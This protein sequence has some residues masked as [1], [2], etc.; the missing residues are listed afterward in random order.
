MRPRLESCLW[1]SPSVKT[2]GLCQRRRWRRRLSRTCPSAATEKTPAVCDVGAAARPGTICKTG[3]WFST[4]SHIWKKLELL[5]LKRKTIFCCCF[6][7][8]DISRVSEV[9]PALP[10]LSVDSQRLRS[11][12]LV[13]TWWHHRGGVAFVEPSNQTTRT[14]VRRKTFR[15]RFPVLPEGEGRRSKVSREDLWSLQ[16]SVSLGGRMK[17]NTFPLLVCSKSRMFFF[18][19]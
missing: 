17:W 12:P 3:F 6:Y 15:Q 5:Q 9:E 19:L 11:G 2:L 13:W 16:N 8:T 14:T 7:R 4:S 18:N 10:S 1:V